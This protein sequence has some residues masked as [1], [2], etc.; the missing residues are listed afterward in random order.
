MECKINRE[1]L[2]QSNNY[3]TY[4]DMIWTTLPKDV[5]FIVLEFCGI[6]K[7][8]NGKYIGQISK[9]DVRYSLLQS[10]QKPKDSLGGKVFTGCCIIELRVEFKKIFDDKKYNFCI[11]RIIANDNHSKCSRMIEFI[12]KWRNGRRISKGHYDC[13]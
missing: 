1:Y 9:T 10:I 6:I 8:R 4:S 7:N 12:D 3:Y 13:V 11:S 2:I 5:R